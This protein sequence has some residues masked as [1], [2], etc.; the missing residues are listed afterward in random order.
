MGQE[1]TEGY[2]LYILSIRGLRKVL[3]NFSRGSWK[4]LEKSWIFYQ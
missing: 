2:F 1:E 3:E 4:V